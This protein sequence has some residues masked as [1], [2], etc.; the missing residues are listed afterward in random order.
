VIAFAMIFYAF[1]VL[2]MGIISRSD[3]HGLPFGNKIENVLLKM[4]LIRE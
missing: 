1:L 2:L 3:I 4:K